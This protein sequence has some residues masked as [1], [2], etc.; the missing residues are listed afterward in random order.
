MKKNSKMKHETGRK[1]LIPVLA[2]LFII[3]GFVA[4]TGC[5][6]SN[7]DSSDSETMGVLVVSHQIDNAMPDRVDF[8]RFS[9]LDGEKVII[10]SSREHDKAEVIT[11]RNVPLHTAHLKIEYCDAPDALEKDPVKARQQAT[12][13]GTTTIPATVS[14]NGE[15]SVSVTGD[16]TG[17]VHFAQS[18]GQWTMMLGGQ[19]G[20]AKGVGGDYGGS[21]YNEFTYSYLTDNL[22]A[23]GANAI[24]VY[25]S[26]DPSIQERDVSAV[27]ALADKLSTND[28]KVYVLVGF[29]FKGV[30]DPVTTNQQAFDKIINDPNVDHVMGWCLG[31]EVADAANS[32]AT[33][34][35][36]INTLATYIKTKSSLPVMTAVPNPTAGA[37][38]TYSTGMPQLDCLA[39]NSF[40]GQYNSSWVQTGFLDQLGS[41]MSANWTKPWFV[42]EFYSYDLPSIA[43]GGYQGMPNQTINGYQ[44]F[45]ELNST[46]NAQ[47][48]T[49]CW[50]NYV[51]GNST[52]GCVG[53]FVLNWIP[54]HNS[55]V[56]GFWKDMF[57]YRGHWENYVNW[58]GK[59]GV[60]RLQA[61]DAI[62]QVYGGTAPANQCPQIVT[63][64]DGDLQGI[65]CTFKA[66]LTSAGTAVNPG[67]SLTAT[68]TATD[69]DQLTFDWY[70]LGGVSVTGSGGG[71]TNGPSINT[72]KAWGVASTNEPVITSSLIGNGT[73]TDL[74][75][76]QQKNT[77]TF[78][79]DP[80]TT[81]GNNY[82]L[83]VIVRDGSG[84]AATA[85]IG[86]QVSSGN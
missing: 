72:Y 15:S 58:Y 21:D 76:N 62:T 17:S 6:G 27:L 79:L 11:L 51:Q 2:A 78:T 86:F 49:D 14:S 41:T 9:F 84:G 36:Q 56:P 69:S 8:F 55:Q 77:I 66:T 59:Y 19:P 25:G 61:V 20:F 4:I 23:S 32:G 68:V 28:K 71:I 57:V 7:S 5:G 18:N 64:A 75:N 81:Q 38:Q 12:V 70:L 10:E 3:L 45:L 53:G 65:D 30:T 44:Y 74:G 73:T 35:T 80:N 34:N 29:V 63:P 47:N 46:A 33:I 1:L 40:Y 67:D 60:D 43:F 54:P 22:P 48:Y 13:V 37:L 83:R 52:N 82:Q 24:R 42:S 26:G 50:N 31:N 39:I 16:P 85:A